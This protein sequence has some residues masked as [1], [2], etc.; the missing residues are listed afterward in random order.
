MDVRSSPPSAYVRSFW[1]N[2]SNFQYILF[3]VTLEN[4]MFHRSVIGEQCC[5]CQTTI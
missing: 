5:S 2:F 4:E 3:Y 1:I